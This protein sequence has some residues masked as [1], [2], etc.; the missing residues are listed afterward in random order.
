MKNQDYIDD[1]LG[2]FFAQEELNKEEKKELELWI[3]SHPEEFRKLKHI[4]AH[5]EEQLHKAPMFN[6][7]LAWKKV[8][9]QLQTQKQISIRPWKIITAIAASLVVVWLAVRLIPTTE[10]LHYENRTASIQNVLLPDSSEVILFPNAAIDCRIA[11]AS[12]DRKVSMDGKVFFKVKRDVNRK[13][14]IK[15]DET[16]VEVLGTSFIIDASQNNQTK[17][18]VRTGKVKVSSGSSEVEL[19]K[20]EQVEISGSKITMKR[21]EQPAS[22]FGFVQKLLVVQDEPLSEV[23][24]QIETLCGVRIVADAAIEKNRITTHLDLNRM[25]EVIRE[26]AELCQCQYQKTDE[27]NY[28]LFSK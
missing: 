27:Q 15:A 2:K 16:L 7:E 9:P 12:G 10:S 21:I 8:E 22:V 23:T 24:R 3:D 17:V 11:E 6:A 5:T 26:L 4:M 25:E 13:F 14:Q 18:Q 19:E 20:N 1:L 28:R